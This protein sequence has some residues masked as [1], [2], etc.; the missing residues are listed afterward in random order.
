MNVEAEVAFTLDV[1]LQIGHLK[2]IVNP[3]D[4]E[5]WE[6]RIFSSGLEQFVE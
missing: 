3:I 6:P 2:V 1:C 4:N 5:I